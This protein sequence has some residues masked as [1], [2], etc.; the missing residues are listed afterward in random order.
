MPRLP[1]GRRTGDN[2]GELLFTNAQAPMKKHFTLAIPPVPTETYNAI[3]SRV[4]TY[5]PWLGQK[6][7]VD[8]AHQRAQAFHENL[9]DAQ[10]TLKDLE[11]QREQAVRDVQEVRQSEIQYAL[12]GIERS[13]QE[14]YV[15]DIKEKEKQWEKEEKDM[16]EEIDEELA[17]LRADLEKQHQQKL[18][19]ED[20]VDKADEYPAKR[21]K[22]ALSNEVG[23]SVLEN[24]E[25]S[26]DASQEEAKLDEPQEK[27]ADE[28]KLSF[29][30]KQ[31]V[32]A[33]QK[34]A[35]DL[36]SL[37]SDML[38]LILQQFKIKSK[39]AKAGQPS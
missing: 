5:Q 14:E 13:I 1:V 21:A 3:A 17:R 7:Q 36:V 8:K 27:A 9:L 29:A 33:L 28:N 30:K 16:E 23:G 4:A 20:D 38:W 10:E 37:K 35:D 15:E 18:L 2:P 34:K 24:S 32:K 26:P 39:A 31:E 25:S 22:L 6:S 19:D 11:E 12:Q